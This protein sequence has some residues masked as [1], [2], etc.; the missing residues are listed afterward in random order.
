MCAVGAGMPH[1]TTDADRAKSAA[2]GVSLQSHRY[3][4]PWLDIIAARF[5]LLGDPL[6][7]RLLMELAV[8]ERSVGE[9]VEATS[10]SQPNVSKHLAALANAGLVRRRKVGTS[11]LYALDDP[12]V[13]TVCDVICAQVRGRVEE[14]AH[15][16]GFQLADTGR[17]G[18]R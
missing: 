14:Q 18:D 1:D 10:A 7:L 4:E 13:F 8:G 2:G 17:T 6:R 15:G 3:S 12:S 16:L 11:T 9:L 5:R